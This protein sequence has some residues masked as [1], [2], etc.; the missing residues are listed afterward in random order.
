MFILANFIE[1][2]AMIIH[3][4]LQFYL[5]IV[6]ARA[7]LSWVNPD[8]YNPIVRFIHNATEPILYRIRTWIPVMMGGIDF[9]P[10][11]VLLGI[12]F[13]DKFVVGS[14]LVASQKM[15]MG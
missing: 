2:V 12:I 10:I 8:P 14:L 13:L 3:Y 4:I 5:L 15:L 1:A 9:S 7:V 11:I 6:V